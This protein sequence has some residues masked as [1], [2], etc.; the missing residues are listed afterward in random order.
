MRHSIIVQMDG[1]PKEPAFCGLIMLEWT[2]VTGTLTT[3]AASAGQLTG[4][5]AQA[6]ARWQRVILSL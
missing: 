3:P 4:Q 1:Q 5:R 2:E 6:A